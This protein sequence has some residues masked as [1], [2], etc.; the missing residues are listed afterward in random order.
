MSARILRAKFFFGSTVEKI[1]QQLYEFLEKED[2]CPGNYISSKLY[3]NGRVYQYELLYA[4]VKEEKR[5]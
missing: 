4:I 2:L 3:K 5:I 1:E